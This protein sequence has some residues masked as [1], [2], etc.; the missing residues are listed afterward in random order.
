MKKLLL[1]ASCVMSFSCF[2]AAT[3]SKDLALAPN[4]QQSSTGSPTFCSEFVT[5]AHCYCGMLFQQDW[6]NKRSM[7]ELYDMMV[8]SSPKRTQESGCKTQ[9]A[10]TGVPYQ[11]CMEHWSHYRSHC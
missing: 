7:G 3:D 10:R 6:C 2:A 11:I 4:C 8:Q 9:E 5:D 1:I